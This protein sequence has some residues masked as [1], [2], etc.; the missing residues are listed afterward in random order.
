MI[1][2][3]QLGNLQSIVVVMDSTDTAAFAI[4]GLT[5]LCSGATPRVHKDALSPF[6]IGIRDSYYIGTPAHAPPR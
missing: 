2:T 6:G 5:L 3:C 4:A 1:P